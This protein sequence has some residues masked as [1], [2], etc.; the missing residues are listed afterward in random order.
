MKKGFTL[1]EVLVVMLISTVVIGALMI[2]MSAGR[3]SWYSGDTQI[4]VQQELRK[5]LGQ[6]SDDL[7]LS[8]ESQIS[9][10]ANGIPYNATS[11]NVSQ[12]VLSTGA[13]NWS[14]NPIV[15][16]LA[17]GQIMRTQG[18]SVRVVANNITSMIFVRQ[19]AS[20]DV[21]RINLTAQK[22]TPFGHI[23][24]ATVASAVFLRN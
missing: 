21:V 17:S 4:S 23:L 22:A 7:R 8:S 24:N 5:A 9:V 13:I 16:A 18:A 20:S 15:Y 2:T 11:F 1:I 19:T 10:L 6:I 14:A 12:G 3:T